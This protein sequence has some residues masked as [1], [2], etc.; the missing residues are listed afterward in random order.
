MLGVIAGLIVYRHERLPREFEW[1]TTIAHF[2]M[3][4][5]LV[6]ALACVLVP[7]TI[8]DDGDDV[9]YHVAVRA[10]AHDGVFWFFSSVLAAQA[11]RPSGKP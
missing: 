11:R 5:V 8:G 7:V 4:D 9:T 1:L 10:I 3:I 6:A 2:S